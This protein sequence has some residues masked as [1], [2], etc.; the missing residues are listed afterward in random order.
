MNKMTIQELIAQFDDM[1]DVIQRA[2]V[3]G[4]LRT[5][6]QCFVMDG[7]EESAAVEAAWM[8]L[9]GLLESLKK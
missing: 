6:Y 3:Q 8:D 2:S 1:E 9:K 7:M 4:F 5:S